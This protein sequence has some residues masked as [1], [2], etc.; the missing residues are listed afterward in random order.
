MYSYFPTVITDN[1]WVILFTDTDRRLRLAIHCNSKLWQ[2]QYFAKEGKEDSSLLRVSL[3]NIIGT[4][5]V[6]LVSTLYKIEPK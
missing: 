4:V 3:N 5:F 2:F 1:C 6:S